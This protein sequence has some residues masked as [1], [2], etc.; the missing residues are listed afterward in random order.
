MNEPVRTQTMKERTMRKRWMI[1][2]LACLLAPIVTAAK[3]EKAEV[4]HENLLPTTG[5]NDLCGEPVFE[6]APNFSFSAMHNPAGPDPIPLTPQLCAENPD[7]LLATWANPGFYAANGW[8][9]PDAR[10]LNIPYHQVPVSVD[11]DGRRMFVVDHA[12]GVSPFPPTRS[13]PNQPETLA[14][15]IGVEGRMKLKCFSDGTAEIKIKAK[16]YP[17]NSLLTLWM[18]WGNAPES[19]LPPVIPQPLGGLP[20]AA[21][22]DSDGK[23][24]FERFLGF[25]PMHDVFGLS[26]PLAID[27]A[28]HPDEVIYGGYP[29]A[30][31]V[32]VRFTDPVTSEVFVTQGNGPGVSS[33][34]Q[35]VFP[36]LIDG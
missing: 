19:G 3:S 27:I 20:N 4:F 7:A 11:W 10:L 32:D 29:D 33:L 1:A 35:G 21:V 15:F 23:F 24:E 9:Q 8:P 5:F 34:D 30:P 36:L 26:T 16:G 6:G 31:L 12:A 22:A 28:S 17:P 25:C 18:V 13:F 14:S 2:L